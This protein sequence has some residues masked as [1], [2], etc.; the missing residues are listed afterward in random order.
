VALNLVW[1]GSAKTQTLTIRGA[2][3]AQYQIRG[4]KERGKN[5]LNQ[6]GGFLK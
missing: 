1:F 6:M 5:R 3:G 4:N 2:I